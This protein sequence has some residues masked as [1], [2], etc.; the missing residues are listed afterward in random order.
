MIM[1]AGRYFKTEDV[2]NMSYLIKD[3]PLQTLLLHPTLDDSCPAL[4]ISV[5]RV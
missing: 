1:I 2:V 5:L 4:N 3:N